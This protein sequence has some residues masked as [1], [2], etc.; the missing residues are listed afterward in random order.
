MLGATFDSVI[1]VGDIQTACNAADRHIDLRPN[2][3]DKSNMQ[4]KVKWFGSSRYLQRPQ[5]PG[6]CC[7]YA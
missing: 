4:G 3:T 2:K 5:L 6:E 1:F 7:K